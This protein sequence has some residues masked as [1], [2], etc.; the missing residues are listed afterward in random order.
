MRHN[1]LSKVKE[2]APFCLLFVFSFM[3]ILNHDKGGKLSGFLVI[4]WVALLVLPKYSQVSKAEWTWIAL[5]AVLFVSIVPSYFFSENSSKADREMERLVKWIFLPGVV[6]FI[7]TRAKANLNVKIFMLSLFVLSLLSGLMGLYD[8][9]QGNAPRN[10]LHGNYI[11]A[12]FIYASLMC[13]LLP[14]CFKKHYQF[15]A[16]ASFSLTSIALLATETRGAWL[17]ILLLMP[18]Y[19]IYKLCVNSDFDLKLK[20]VLFASFIAVS[21]ITV[22]LDVFQQR[23][24]EAVSDIELYIESPETQATTSLGT[25]FEIFH[26]GFGMIKDYPWFGV[27][28]GDIGLHFYKYDR[29]GQVSKFWKDPRPAPNMHNELIN[30][31]VTKGLISTAVYLLLFV[32]LA[33]Y[34]IKRHRGT[35]NQALLSEIGLLFI[36]SILIEGLSY[37]VLVSHNGITLFII[38]LGVLIRF[39]EQEEITR[40][41]SAAI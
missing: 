39:I 28:L 1:W 10:L 22:Q 33:I 35:D 27:G 18:I 6:A 20:A 14:F 40:L 37:P 12:G 7:C 5:T 36:S 25:R 15:I 9:R 24:S 30:H 19:V 11:C 2:A 41:K 3:Q 34:F 13:C 8:L 16:I 29:F 17:V 21:S 38:L 32:F 23:L 31:A 26:A 4:I